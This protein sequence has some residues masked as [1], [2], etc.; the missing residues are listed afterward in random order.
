MFCGFVLP[1][2]VDFSYISLASSSPNARLWGLWS[3]I[4]RACH[5]FTE[6]HALCSSFLFLAHVL[7][8]VPECWLRPPGCI[9]GDKWRLLISEQHTSLAC[10]HLLSFHYMP[11]ELS[12]PFPLCLPEQM[13]SLMLIKTIKSHKSC[14]VLN[15]I[16]FL[17]REA[18]K[19]Y[20]FPV[21]RIP[22]GMIRFC[23]RNFAA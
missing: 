18:L 11:A 16:L 7:Q 23:L 8:A 4:G 19:F 17:Q 13:T 21:R 10:Y 14:R 12:N 6:S 22:V 15:R 5:S 2:L 9:A 20:N 3:R 1:C